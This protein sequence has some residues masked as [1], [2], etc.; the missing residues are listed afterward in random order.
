MAGRKINILIVDDSDLFIQSISIGLKSKGYNIRVSNN[1]FD[2]IASIK[3]NSPDIV[4][5]DLE[6]PQINGIDTLKGIREFDKNLPVIIDS[7]SFGNN[8]K[9]IEEILALGV[10]GLFSKSSS[11]DELFGLIESAVVKK[12][13]GGADSIEKG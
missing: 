1:G 3:K 9:R 10:C 12:N 5:L 13:D 11:L 7:S 8:K 4:L 2:A 6:M